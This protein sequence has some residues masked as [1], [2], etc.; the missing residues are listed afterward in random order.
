MPTATM[1]LPV[2]GPSK[3]SNEECNRTTTNN[4]LC[5]PS[6]VKARTIFT[7][8][9]SPGLQ[10]VVFPSPIYLNIYIP[11][12]T[13]NTC[14]IQPQKKNSE[15]VTQPKQSNKFHLQFKL[16][17]K[18]QNVIH[19][20]HAQGNTNEQVDCSFALKRIKT[21]SLSSSSSSSSSKIP[22][23][24]LLEVVEKI[25]R[26][27]KFTN[28]FLQFKVDQLESQFRGRQVRKR[29]RHGAVPSPCDDVGNTC[30]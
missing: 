2:I 9:K 6:R 23:A 14:I 5:L 10:S 13:T 24:Q 4:L 11:S 8:P 28:D 16:C 15:C 20:N 18:C 7:I 17:T 12:F 3:Q 26:K 30:T 22:S 25:G 29:L 21:C 1:A 19:Q 27:A